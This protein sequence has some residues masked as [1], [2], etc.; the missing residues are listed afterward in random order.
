[1][2]ELAGKGLPAD[3]RE[4]VYLEG[5]RLHTA[6]I[7]SLG[8]KHC[9]VRAGTSGSR[10]VASRKIVAYAADGGSESL[11]AAATALAAE[12]DI[13]DLWRAAEGSAEQSVAQLAEQLPAGPEP[14]VRE[15][16]LHLALL[17]QGGLFDPV[18]GGWKPVGA[19]QF[20]VVRQAR[21]RRREREERERGY[22]QE[23]KDGGLPAELAEVLRAYF[24]GEHDPNAP[25]M[26][27]LLSHVK[28]GGG[29]LA[30]LA[31]EHGII[32]D[33]VDYHLLEVRLRQPQPIAEQD[34]P[35]A[36]SLPADAPVLEGGI[37]IDASGTVEVD[38]AFACVPRE[39][40]GHR[41]F[42]CIAAPA[43]DLGPAARRQA[44][45]R[46]LTLYLPG[47]KDMMLPQPA[48]G[49]YSL[50]AGEERPCVALAIDID[51]QGEVVGQEFM[52]AKL[53]VTAN[54]PLE[55]CATE[56]VG[57]LPVDEPQREQLQVLLDFATRTKNFPREQRQRG[58][59]VMRTDGKIAIHARA[60]LA[61]L[62]DLV[63]DLMIYY[64]TAAAQYLIK[65]GYPFIGRR[66]G[67]S[68][69]HH[70]RK[71]QGFAYGWFSSPL[72]RMVDLI[73]QEQLLAALRDEPPVHD[74]N[75]MRELSKDFERR[76]QW[77]QR[78]QQR[79]EKYWTLK[80]LQEQDAQRSFTALPLDDA[81]ASK[82]LL[83]EIGLH[84][85]LLDDPLAPGEQ[86]A[87]TLASCD[88]FHLTAQVRRA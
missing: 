86:P 2:P 40:G 62:D 63:A 57:H 45:E 21:Q 10:R 3:K 13:E 37:A 84:A 47:A 41:C 73:N 32:A 19:Q 88:L 31:Y 44:R 64:N 16:A 14:A 11:A 69:I 55:Q 18:A 78:Q 39:G 70:A 36:P 54:V 60:Q 72:R 9:V 56:D 24:R 50:D 30:Q 76:F 42:I 81:D 80:W 20:E 46:M 49:C 75:S 71:R 58:H 27:F 34:D 51:E 77:T 35:P 85:E 43:L 87:V 68:A 66:E 48:L 12:L 79:L 1:M 74:V 82:V 67:R 7:Q 29:S 25:A 4:L 65:R 38:D 26:R 22:L 17:R 52:Q 23:L 8:T 5:G 59:L 33:I 83:A 28:Q 15:A 53:R 61:L 6:V